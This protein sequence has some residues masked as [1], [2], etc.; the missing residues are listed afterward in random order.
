MRFPPPILVIG[1]LATI[2][3]PAVADLSEELVATARAELPD[4]MVEA[5]EPGATSGSAA[6]GRWSLEA[7]QMDGQGSPEAVLIILPAGR[8]GKI[9]FFAEREGKKPEKK[10]VKLKGSPVVHASVAFHEFTEGR[11]IAHVDGGESGQIILHWTGQKLEEV[12]KIGRVRDDERHWFNLDDLDGDGIS[13]VIRFFRRELDV[14]TNED[15]LAG[16][17]GAADRRQSGGQIDAV[18]VYR[19]HDGKW[20]GDKALLESLK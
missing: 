18:A 20:K 19:W 3:S 8:P 6:W 14:F 1:L 12:W 4:E 10:K 7:G 13:E 15:E 5:A 17:G 2:A 9:F 11:A 16:E